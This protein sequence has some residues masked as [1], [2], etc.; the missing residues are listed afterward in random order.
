MKIYVALGA[1]ALSL[2]GSVAHAQG[3]QCYNGYCYETQ[4]YPYQ[5]QFQQN[6]TTPQY[7]PPGQFQFQWPQ[8][9]P[10]DQYYQ[11]QQQYQQQYNP[12]DDALRGLRSPGAAL[13]A[14]PKILLYPNTAE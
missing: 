7:D 14:I 4:Q 13:W 10:Y 12:Y 2:L 8:I 5:P 3:W 1:F 9:T 6:W 11:Q